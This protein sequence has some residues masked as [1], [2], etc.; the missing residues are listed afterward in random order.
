MLK[1]PNSRQI[2][3]VSGTNRF[4][5]PLRRNARLLN[6]WLRWGQRPY[7]DYYLS[8]MD[9]A[10]MQDPKGAV[11]GLWDTLGRLQI[12]FLRSQGLR[13]DHSLLDIG[14]GCLRGGLHFIGYLEP[15]HYWGLDISPV[16]LEAG[17]SFLRQAELA[18]K[19]P[20]LSLTEG[21]TFYEVDGK[22]F[23]FV[24]AFAIF[25]D[26]PAGPIR[27]CFANL[28][29][30]LSPEGVCFATFRPGDRRVS[31]PPGIDFKYPFEF[32]KNLGEEAGYFVELAEGFEHPRGHQMLA[33]RHLSG[34]V[35]RQG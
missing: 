17:R 24:W 5:R 14:C 35:R 21:F 29:K 3:L 19:S 16:I 27:A 13:P 33:M 10:A 23:D 8:V 11:G 30:V 4:I 28:H 7:Q 15:G 34:N 31:Y 9:A 20:R 2:D 18:H 6:W 32:F 1:V 12:D 22:Q 26:M 25:S